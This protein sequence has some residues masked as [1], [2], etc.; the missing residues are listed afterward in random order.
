MACFSHTTCSSEHRT[1]VFRNSWCYVVVGDNIDV[2]RTTVSSDQT[3]T[4]VSVT[5]HGAE[6]SVTY[7]NTVK[8]V[9][10]EEELF[11]LTRAAQAKLVERSFWFA[12]ARIGK[13]LKPYR[14]IEH[15]PIKFGRSR[16]WTGKNYRKVSSGS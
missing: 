6:T 7:A 15:R 16:Q 5:Y 14:A 12:P 11:K 2:M 13:A 3:G 1:V 9:S 8:S 4:T 10:H